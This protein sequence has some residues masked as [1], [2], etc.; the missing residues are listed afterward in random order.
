MYVC[1]YVYAG[2]GL[3]PSSCAIPKPAGALFVIDCAIFILYV[4]S[5]GMSVLWLCVCVVVG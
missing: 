5:Y 1:Y 3:R 2:Y 4:P